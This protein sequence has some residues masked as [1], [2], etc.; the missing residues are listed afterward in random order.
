MFAA[1]TNAIDRASRRVGYAVGP[2]Y[3]LRAEQLAVLESCFEYLQTVQTRSPEVGSPFGRIV[4]PPRTGKTVIAGHLIAHSGLLTAF[5]VP[6]RTLV[7]QTARELA[8]QIPSLPIGMY[9]GS[10]KELVSHGV[11]ITTYAQLQ[12]SVLGD[13][14]LPPP[15]RNAGLLFAD[16]AHH[17][18][19]PQRVKLLRSSFS[20]TTVRIG[21]TATPDY[22]DDRVL[23][24][25]F[26]DLIHEI[27]L[28]E[29][30]TL[31][32]LAPLR[33]WC[34]EVDAQGS[35]VHVV[36]G[37]YDEAELGRVMTAAP[38]LRAVEWFRYHPHNA[39]IPA[40]IT[41]VTRQ[42]A[43]DLHGYL[44]KHRPKGTPS[45]GLVLGDTPSREREAVLAA[46]ER[47][48]I[49]TL[50]QVG[51]LTEGWNSPR[52]KLLLDLAPSMSRVRA[53]QKFFRVL[54]K[55]EDAEA[56][57][58]LLLPKGLPALPIL[59]TE[60]FGASC[61]QVSAGELIGKRLRAS[62]SGLAPVETHKDCPIAGVSLKQRILYTGRFSASLLS[63]DRPDHIRAVLRTNRAFDPARPCSHLRFLGIVFSHPVFTGRGEALLR[64]YGVPATSSGYL[65]FL[66]SV[67]PEVAATWLLQQRDGVSA[68]LCR[69][70]RADVRHLKA[71]ST[72]V[73]RAPHLPLRMTRDE[74]W[75]EG[76][77]AIGGHL[78]MPSEQPLQVLLNKED[79]KILDEE[80]SRFK[81]RTAR[82]VRKRFG[83]W[84]RREY[85]YEELGCEENVSSKA[86][87]AIVSSALFR[88]GKRLKWEPGVGLVRRVSLSSHFVRAR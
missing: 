53:T 82:L 35:R 36:A 37:D 17:A 25:F 27:T 54:T 61:Q 52:C 78:Q 31:G 68:W 58:Y 45:P 57:I 86:I 23:C 7:E 66:S 51:V 73:H 67:W 62:A 13:E 72:A 76:F 26:P 44:Q 41:C 48:K 18:M 3:D 50:L 49:D 11:N 38:F 42:Q 69:H 33:M 16:E 20:Q 32:L 55:R 1:E 64:W 71:K 29:A 40:L 9:Y 24:R 47:G 12:P 56:R 80:L 79:G 88:L 2:G 87:G 21:L 70:C 85:T 74:A 75:I 60:L 5:L 39:L 77:L 46:F 34:A 59:P 30:V 28:D 43:H 83:L 81:N 22:R 8:K 6:T 4:L 65:A 63:R 84:D 19:T 14:P 10:K 15:L